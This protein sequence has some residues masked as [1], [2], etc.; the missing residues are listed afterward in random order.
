MVSVISLTPTMTYD[1]TR[2]DSLEILSL[3]ARGLIDYL[4]RVRAGEKDP[5]PYPEYL[6][7]GFNQLGIACVLQGID[8]TKR[9]S[10]IPEFVTTWG[11]LPLGA[12][13]LK[14]EID[15]P[16]FSSDDYLIEPEQQD[17][18]TRLCY[19]L[20]GISKPVSP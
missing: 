5:F 13:P 17:R 7:R 2:L 14:L 10:S 19:K 15:S 8:R 9:P 1:P 20:A 6:L 16:G 18:P 4:E 12:W 11:I 3:L